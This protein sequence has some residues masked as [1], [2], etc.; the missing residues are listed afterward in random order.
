MSAPAS[1]PTVL[2]F[3]QTIDALP[4]GPQSATDFE[5]ALRLALEFEKLLCLHFAWEKVPDIHTGLIDVLHNKYLI[6]LSLSDRRPNGSPSTVASI[7][8]F[9][10][11]WNLFTHGVLQ[12]LTNWDNMIVTGGSVLAALVPIKA[13]TDREKLKIY[14]SVNAMYN[15]SDINIFLWGLKPGEAK[16][17]IREIFNAILGDGPNT[18]APV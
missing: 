9:K 5:N 10:E 6:P 13:A 2:N 4:V 8:E 15:S 1:S 18:H 16:D 7:E 14:H 3:I 12:S 17:K 11:N